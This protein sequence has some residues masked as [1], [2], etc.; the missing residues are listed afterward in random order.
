MSML[1][2]IKR[3][4]SQG[5]K[6]FVVSIE[7][8]HASSRSQILT[9]GILEDPLFM[10][11]V[12]KN[13]KSFEDFLALPKEELLEIINSQD[14]LMGILARAIQGMSEQKIEEN[15]SVS[16]NF[17]KRVLSEVAY[18]KE[19]TILERET[20]KIYLLKNVRK[21]QALGEIEGFG[22]RLPPLILFEPQT[23][24]DGRAKIMYDNGKLAAEGDYEKS[25]RTGYWIHNYDTG[26]IF[27]EGDYSQ[28]LKTG[29]WV[30]YFGNGDIKAQ[31]KFKLDQKQ[32]LWKEWDRAGKCT[33]VEYSAGTKVS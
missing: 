17:L 29:A 30:F 24:R 16:P 6:D 18:Q 27:A 25:K 22:W 28:G 3:Q 33:E 32:G 19:P 20:A 9:I 26:K 23:H 5:F 11:W 14:A 4:Q 2:R 12:L 8:A 31:G 13:V 10:A 21:L 1:D 15:F 7:T